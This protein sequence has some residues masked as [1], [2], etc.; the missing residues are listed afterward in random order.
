[1]TV[2]RTPAESSGSRMEHLEH[3]EHSE[4]SGPT[5]PTEQPVRLS[6]VVPTRDRRT[7]LRRTVGTLLEEILEFELP[8]EVVV[9]DDG[10][11]E[12]AEPWLRAEFPNAP[13][14]VLRHHT[15]RG[16]GAARN[17]GA[18]SSDGE[19]IAFLDDDIVPSPDLVRI[20]LQTHEAHPDARV[21]NGNLRPLR[22]DIYSRFWF[23]HYDAAF[24]VGRGDREA[25]LYEVDLLASGHCSIQRALLDEIEPLFDP[26]LA[27]GEDVDLAMRLRS[28]GTAILKADRILAWND[29]RRTFVGF[30]KQYAGYARGVHDLE[31]KHGTEALAALRSGVRPRPSLGLLHLSLAL[32]LMRVFLKLRPARAEPRGPAD[33]TP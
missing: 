25:G 26:S 31:A 2:L 27:T 5:E 9:V 32:R 8:A 3:S 12:P 17:L 33:S 22:D 4:H 11:L 6:I 7:T 24:N 13:L 28:R 23:H 10:S 14:R 29:C 30:L 15:S 1:M 19:I 20:T 18:A 16:P 21:L